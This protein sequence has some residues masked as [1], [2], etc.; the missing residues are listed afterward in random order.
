MQDVWRMGVHTAMQDMSGGSRCQPIKRGANKIPSARSVK[1]LRQ[2]PLRRLMTITW[3]A[4]IALDILKDCVQSAYIGRVGY[5]LTM[6]KK[7]C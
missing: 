5:G 7:R 6:D 4:G 2:R 3:M 1:A